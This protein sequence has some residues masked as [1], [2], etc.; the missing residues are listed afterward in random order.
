MIIDQPRPAAEHAA[1]T[2]ALVSAMTAFASLALPCMTE[3]SGWRDQQAWTGWFLYRK[4]LEDGRIIVP[5]PAVVVLV[6]ATFALVLA[7]WYWK[8]NPDWRRGPKVMTWVGVASLAGGLLL[9]REVA[10]D[11]T[12]RAPTNVAGGMVLWFVSMLLFTSAATRLRS[13]AE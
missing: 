6:V 4:S 1:H 7:A 11:L 3:G 9:L 8:A 10:H 13:L 2:M 12:G 5:F